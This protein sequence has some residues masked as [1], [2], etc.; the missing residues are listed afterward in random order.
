[1]ATSLNLYTLDGIHR[2][3][4]II[5][6]ALTTQTVLRHG[7]ETSCGDVHAPH[8]GDHTKEEGHVAPVDLA[9]AAVALKLARLVLKQRRRPLASLLLHVIEGRR[10]VVARGGLGGGLG[11]A[12][13]S[14]AG[15][16]LPARIHS[17]AWSLGSGLQ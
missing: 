1:M 8:Q 5:C 7:N 10:G 14:A 13:T 17:R 9:D 6:P 16:A 12:S 4:C 15:P 2:Q 11:G 3:V